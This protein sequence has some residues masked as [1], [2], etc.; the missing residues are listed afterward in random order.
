[1]STMDWLHI[2]WRLRRQLLDA[3]R[4]L[5]FGGL[6]ISH[7]E[8]VKNKDALDLNDSDLDPANK[9]SYIGALKIFDFRLNQSIYEVSAW[10][11][12]FLMSWITQLSCTI[13]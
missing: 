10:D 3:N 12:H 2:I 7:V 9:Q 13:L 8:L 4:R 5:D 6:I 11:T 1:M